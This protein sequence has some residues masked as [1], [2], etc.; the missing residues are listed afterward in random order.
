MLQSRGDLDEAIKLFEINCALHW[1]S[2]RCHERL[3]A[4]WLE[5]GN[6]ENA[7]KSAERALR[8][9]EDPEHVKELTSLIQETEKN[10]S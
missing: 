7:H 4:A 5:S 8:Y 1:E 10:G 9:N 2:A 3:A 6:T